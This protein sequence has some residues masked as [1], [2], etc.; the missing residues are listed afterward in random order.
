FPHQLPEAQARRLA[1]VTA[2]LLPTPDY[3]WPEEL[4]AGP[5]ALRRYKTPQGQ[6]HATRCLIESTLQGVEPFRRL[7]RDCAPSVVI[8][9]GQVWPA[10][11]ACALERVPL[12]GMCA[13]LQAITPRIFGLR[14][15]VAELLASA[16]ARFG[17]E[18]DFRAG[19][20]VSP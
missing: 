2:E 12:I 15:E 18:G 4:R 14:G 10:S 1:A 11:I 9:D 3:H 6:E 19:A 16:F 20:A 5:D 17:V 7:L 13:G 8:A